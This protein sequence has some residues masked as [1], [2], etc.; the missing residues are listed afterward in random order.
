MENTP[1]NTEM[2]TEKPKKGLPWK[3]IFITWFALGLIHA[4]ILTFGKG[5]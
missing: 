3:K 5:H 4:L 2:D 1:K